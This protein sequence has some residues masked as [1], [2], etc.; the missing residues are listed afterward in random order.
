LKS[1]QQPR[2]V[3]RVADFDP[4]SENRKQKIQNL[5]LEKFP[6]ITFH[7]LKFSWKTKSI[8][9]FDISF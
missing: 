6:L 4:L 9:L 5:I 7:R 3:D 1:V 2:K 8:S